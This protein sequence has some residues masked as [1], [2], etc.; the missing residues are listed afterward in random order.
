MTGIRRVGVGGGGQGSRG[1]R[2]ECE[3]TN[4]LTTL[5]STAKKS[6]WHIGLQGP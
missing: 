4:K 5:L 6:G 2:Q 3:S 1:D